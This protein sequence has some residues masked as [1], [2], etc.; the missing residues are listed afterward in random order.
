MLLV[1]R[2]VRMEDSSVCHWT[3]FTAQLRA[4]RCPL[5]H[6]MQLHNVMQAV[7]RGNSKHHMHSF[8]L[9]CSDVDGAAPGWQPDWKVAAKARHA[10][11]RLFPLTGNSTQH[12]R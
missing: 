12:F 8:R 1:L 9:D 5:L 11:L 6:Q 3:C 4:A 2:T 7:S 10:S